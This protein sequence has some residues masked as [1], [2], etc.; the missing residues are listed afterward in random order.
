VGFNTV[1]VLYNDCDFDRPDMGLRIKNAM[2]GWS[3]RDRFPMETHFGAGIV[4]SQAHADYPQV[5]IVGHN[6]GKRAEDAVGLDRM[7]LD[8][9]VTCLVNHGY[10]VRAPAKPKRAPKKSLARL[11][12]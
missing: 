7:A 3:I 10:K 1:A 6:T 4:I 11:G 8:Q 2:R 5:V 9:M 12:G